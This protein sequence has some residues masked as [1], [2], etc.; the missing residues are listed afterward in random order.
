[1][2][3]LHYVLKKKKTAFL[4]GASLLALV[5]FSIAQNDNAA[6]TQVAASDATV[7]KK[8]PYPPSD[9]LHY[10]KAYNS[11]WFYIAQT[12][13]ENNKTF[14]L[15]AVRSSSTKPSDISAHLLYGITDLTTGGYTHGILPGTF[16]ETNNRIALSFD[17]KGQ[18]IMRFTEG[19]SGL[20]GSV[21]KSFTF[22]TKLLSLI[23]TLKF[24]E[25]ILYE[26]GDGIVPMAPGLNSLYVSL[27]PLGSTYWADFQKFK[28]ALLK[29]AN[30]NPLGFM[31]G[32]TNGGQEPNHR[33]GSIVLNGKA[34][35]LPS[36]T[37]IVYWD[38][39]DKNGNP[40]PGGFTNIDVLPPGGPQHNAGNFS[41]KE[42]DYWVGNSKT[43]LRKWRLVQPTLGV[44]LLVETIIQDQEFKIPGVLD[45]YEG[46][47]IVRDPA[48][49]MVVGSGMWEE[50]HNEATDKK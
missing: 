10:N 19:K 8:Y 44:D 45:F 46:A 49:G 30:S 21:P 50:T 18:T 22:E 7:Y 20:M 14:W 25:P 6:S 47:V 23:K 48:S 2:N 28:V 31:R 3:V 24:S 26:S 41:I 16:T 5:S 27:A 39:F 35:K 37:A 4:I 17:H 12:V 43:Y 42:L 29:P 38:I 1:M 33:W 36:G 13:P 11:G 15:A 32:M 9:I 34:G 40:Q